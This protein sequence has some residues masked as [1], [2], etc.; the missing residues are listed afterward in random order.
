MSDWWL[1]LIPGLPLL[2]AC[3]VA[4]RVVFFRG[5]GDAAEY[6]S[7]Y[8]VLSANV[9]SLLLI[10]V[11]AVRAVT[12]DAPQHV[13]LLPWLHSGT[14]HADISFRL[15]SLSLS[16]AAVVALL[17]LLVT[18]FSI[19]YLHREPGFQR[20]FMVL[21]LFAAAMQ[22]IILA[23]SAWLVFVGWELAGVSSYLLIAYNWQ[24]KTATN[25]ATRAFVTNR[26]GDAGFLLGLFMAVTWFHSLEWDVVLASHNDVPSLMVGVTTLGFMLAA[27]VKSA[28]FPFS[29]WITGALEGPTPSSTVFYGAVM[30]HAG[31]Y[32]LLRI[33]PLLEQVPVLQYVLLLLGILTLL[34]GWLGGLVQSDIKTSLL[35]STL[36]QTGLMLVE[37]ALGWYTLALGHL[38]LHAIWRTYQFLHSPSFAV[39]VAWQPAPLTTLWLWRWSWLR[40]AALQRFWLDP[41]ADWLLVKPTQALSH[42]AQVFDEQI[43]DKLTGT[44]IHHC[45]IS[46]LAEMQALQQ[47]TLRLENS[48]GVG[49]GVFGKSMQ[50]IAE[51]S[52]WLENCLLLQQDSGKAKQWLERLGGYLDRIERLLTQPRYLMLLVTVTLV[53]IF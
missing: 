33:H 19:N 50:A 9:L 47:R 41:L 53:V 20:F 25:N 34:Y 30:V 7:A 5:R 36:A 39:D 10:V 4:A 3:W 38:L 24:R 14:Y 6:V 17:V 28:Q 21:A 15:D 31:I 35:F 52:E 16:V 32:L 43:L 13:L 8:P 23:G 46:T 26:V 42:E 40:N 45:Y 22:L 27:L 49:S 37:I 29:A 11:A 12:T 44:P 48:V 1:L 2:A 51:H 18:R